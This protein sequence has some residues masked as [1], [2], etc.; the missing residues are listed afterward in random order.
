[1]P[2]TLRG[3]SKSYGAVIA[4]RGVDLAVEGGEIRALYGGNGSG[5]STVAKIVGGIVA[6]D[7]GA[8][9]LDSAPMPFGQ[10]ARA[11]AAGV[12]IAYQELSLLP[13]LSVADNLALGL[14]PE[15]IPWFRDRR[16]IRE[17][18]AQSLRP[19]GLGALAELPVHALQVGEK[20]L[21]ELAKVLRLKPKYI[22]LD[23]VTSALHEREVSIVRKVLAELRAAGAGVILVSHRLQELRAFCDSITVLRNG[24]VVAEGDLST[25]STDRL[26]ELVGGSRTAQIAAG[27]PSRAVVDATHPPRLVVK[28]LELERGRPPV[29]LTVRPGEVVGL[30]GLPDQGQAELL[31]RLMGLR[32]HKTGASIE[33]DGKS[34]ALTSPTRAILSGVAYVSGDRDE[35]GFAIRTI[36]ENAFAA[37]LNR[38]E[39]R[40]PS[41]DDLKRVLHA[42]TTVYGSLSHAL[43]SLSGG[44]QQKVLLARSFLL[45]PKLLLAADP[46]KG[47]DVAARAEVHAFVRRLAADYGTAV[48]LTSSD[49]RE[50]A[51]LCHRVLVL[52]RGAIIRELTA[53]ELN[54]ENLIDAYMR[55]AAPT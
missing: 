35:V 42:L 18:A 38:A 47:I 48:I 45:H 26:V 2:L 21:V 9:M 37:A 28:D 40:R 41:R 12:G 14:I 6:P 24:E 34:V 29:S 32:A 27:R 25:V 16:R 36:E 13:E 52:E 33:I 30:G 46:T 54:E 19:L 55:E 20:Y 7:H 3:L 15:K 22:V 43:K 4:L 8:M 5:K 17:E 39:G 11:Q 23:E 1:M 44:N 49:D 31:A 53:K 50:L 10:P 51:E